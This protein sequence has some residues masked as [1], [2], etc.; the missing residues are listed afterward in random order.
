MNPEAENAKNEKDK[1]RG[2]GLIG[3]FARHPKL[4]K[5]AKIATL[6]ALGIGLFLGGAKVHEMTENKWDTE[7]TPISDEMNENF[8]YQ[9]QM[10]GHYEVDYRAD[11]ANEKGNDYNEKKGGPLDVTSPDRFTGIEDG[12]DEGFRTAFREAYGKQVARQLH[13]SERING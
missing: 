4:A 7:R 6:G 3:F 10:L 8:E 12:D 2:R 9:E 11:F 1:K 5:A 13:R